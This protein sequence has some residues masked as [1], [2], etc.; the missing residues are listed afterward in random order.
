MK[1]TMRNKEAFEYYYS[2][3]HD[4]NLASVAHQYGCSERSVAA[5]SNSS[6][7]RPASSSGIRRM[8]GASSRRPMRRSSPPKPGTARSSGCLQ[9]QRLRRRPSNRTIKEPPIVAGR[10]AEVRRGRSGV[11]VC[12]DCGCIA[13]DRS[14][15]AARPG[16]IASRSPFDT[17]LLLRNKPWIK[18]NNEKKIN[19]FSPL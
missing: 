14:G 13:P 1:E 15:T 7:G 10:L 17:W 2:L 3:G 12:R 4:S 9:P 16:S 19:W 11:S 5:W 18:P 6:T 8:P